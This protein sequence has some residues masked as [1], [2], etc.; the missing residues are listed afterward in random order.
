MRMGADLK[1][2]L[3][4]AV[5]L[6]AAGIASAAAQNYP[7]RPVRVIVPFAPGGPTD[8]FARL[9]SQKLSEQTGKQFYVENVGGAGGTPQPYSSFN[10]NN[11]VFSPAGNGAG[12]VTSA[13]PNTY[14]SN[15]DVAAGFIQLKLM[16][17]PQL[18]ILGGARV[19]NT[20]QD[21]TTVMPKSYTGRAG[22][23]QYTDLLPSIHL[24]YA[25]T[26]N[27][28]IRLSYFRSIVR[29]DFYEIIPTQTNGEIFNLLG[30]DSLKHS[31]ADN[32]DL[33][34]EI[35]PRGGVNQIF[36]GAF[37]KNIQNPI[38]YAITRNGSPSAQYLKPEN[39]GNA[40][41]YGVEAVVTK[42]FGMFG[43]SANYTYTK[44]RITTTKLYFYRDAALGITSKVVDQA[45]PLQGQADNIGNAS[46]LY[47][48]PKIGLDVQVAF[49]YT[50]KRIA[51]VSPYYGLDYWQLGQGTLDFSFEQRLA[52]HFI[53]ALRLLRRCFFLWMRGG[54]GELRIADQLI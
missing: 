19:E 20:R 2:Y 6:L 40:Q 51:Q 50:G 35:F 15:E 53:A 45:R 38:E 12:A 43:V 31:Q 26:A 34:Y 30:N 8:V 36:I 25:I 42:F 47:K 13:S 48:N 23:V 14:T 49:V 1:K 11:Y 28:N 9:M 37:Y 33:R 39:F 52:K 27:Q 54:P 32:F 3:A 18:Q 44:S 16:A 17:T 7:S 24:K 10:A 41:N 4:I 21:F 5:V 22:N 46:L 29:P